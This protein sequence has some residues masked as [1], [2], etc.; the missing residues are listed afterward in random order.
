MFN[1]LVGLLFCVQNFTE[2][3]KLDGKG[4]DALLGEMV[5]DTMLNYTAHFFCLQIHIKFILLENLK[6]TMKF[7]HSPLTP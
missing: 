2:I 7:R 3:T 5:L 6:V 4:L 1:L